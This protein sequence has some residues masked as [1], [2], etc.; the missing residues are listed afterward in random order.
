LAAVNLVDGAEAQH[1]RSTAFAI[2]EFYFGFNGG[3]IAGHF[4]SLQF[5]FAV[6]K[7]KPCTRS[8]WIASG[9]GL[10]GFTKTWFLI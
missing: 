5:R 8:E 2:L 9:T 3:I 1:E 10:V 4:S 7:K 6:K